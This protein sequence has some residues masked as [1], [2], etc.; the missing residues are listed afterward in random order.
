MLTSSTKIYQLIDQ[1]L[2]FP[3]S[4]LL[5]QFMLMTNNHRDLWFSGKT[6]ELNALHE[7]SQTK[8]VFW[9]CSLG[10]EQLFCSKESLSFAASELLFWNTEPEFPTLRSSDRK[11]LIS[12]VQ[13]HTNQTTW[14][15][16]TSRTLLLQFIACSSG[17]GPAPVRECLHSSVQSLQ[18]L[19]GS[20]L[21]QGAH[22]PRLVTLA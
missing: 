13:R 15:Q 12:T 18:L 10:T 3:S 22:K 2:H 6:L 4:L 9:N 14:R 1:P 19:P 11:Q 21:T 5:F 20:K 7:P 16:F 17:A 8:A